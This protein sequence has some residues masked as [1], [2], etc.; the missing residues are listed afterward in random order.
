VV[1]LGDD[2]TLPAAETTAAAMRAGSKYIYQAVFL[3]DGWRGIADFLERIDRPSALG[4]WS[5]QVLDTK[6]A[7]HPRPE[8][9]LQ[10]CFYSH[11]LEQ[12]QKIAPE[13][14]YVVLGT[15]DR[16][17]IRIA[18]VSAYFR[19]LQNRF[20]EAISARSQTAPYPCDHCLMCSYQPICDALGARGPPRTSCRHPP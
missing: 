17:A 14:A 4:D 19:R 1:G 7:R 20:R 11:A 13:M 6:L 15:R 18:N 10:L 12:I 9:A 2:R 16:F 3:P 5:Y 8:H